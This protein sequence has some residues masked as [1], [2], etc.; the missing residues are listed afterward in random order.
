MC[1]FTTSK[2]IKIGQP[3]PEKSGVSK[4][5]GTMNHPV[6]EL[7]TICLLQ[8]VQIN[9]SPMVENNPAKLVY[10]LGNTTTHLKS[11]MDVRIRPRLNL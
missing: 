3:S 11:T 5:R 10:F 4:L 1:L 6:A 9:V 7:T 8:F 2:G